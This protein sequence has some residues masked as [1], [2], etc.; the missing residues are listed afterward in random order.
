MSSLHTT[1]PTVNELGHCI[2]RDKTLPGVEKSENIT[3][4]WFGVSVTGW[5]QYTYERGQ[6]YCIK[7]IATREEVSM[8]RATAMLDPAL[9]DMQL[10]M[11]GDI[12]FSYPYDPKDPVIL[13]YK[14]TFYEQLEN[15]HKPDAVG[16]QT[17]ILQSNDWVVIFSRE[18]N[19][20]HGKGIMIKGKVVHVK[21][22]DGEKLEFDIEKVVFASS[23]HLEDS[24]HMLIL[25]RRHG[26]HH[27]RV[28][29]C[30]SVEEMFA[31]V[32][33]APHVITDRYHPGVASM[34]VGT[35]LTL[36]SYKLEATKMEGLRKM[37]KFSHAE[38]L[39]MN[40]KAFSSLLKVINKE[41]RD[42]SKDPLKE[43]SYRTKKKIEPIFNKP[44]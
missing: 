6:K 2:S 19:F 34:I 25:Q 41:Q 28:Y 13:Q 29:T 27:S 12:S 10:L 38:I 31:L 37:Q 8:Q 11:S 4:V 44:L 30:A 36:T 21:S 14:S 32:S 15:F 24:K 23:S 43:P 33:S 20:G 40:E 1:G 5:A 22:I 26:V 39:A 9:E 42:T 18:N 35:K 7:M 17:S 16:K 3:I